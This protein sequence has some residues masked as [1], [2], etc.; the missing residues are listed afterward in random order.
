VYDSTGRFSTE[1]IAVPGDASYTYTITYNPTTGLLDTLQYPIS[2]ASY[3]MKLQYGYTNGILQHITD[4]SPGGLGT[5]YWAANT[6]N[7]ELA[8][9]FEATG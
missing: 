9:L 2:T 1:T 3:Q 8:P 7:P 5:V 4:I 6:M